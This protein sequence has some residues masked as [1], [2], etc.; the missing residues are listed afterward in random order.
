M[1]QN[2][3]S[4]GFLDIKNIVKDLENSK[5]IDDFEIYE[6]NKIINIKIYKKSKY[7]PGLNSRDCDIYFDNV[8]DKICNM[9]NLCKFKAKKKNRSIKYVRAR[10]Y[11]YI[12]NYL[13]YMK[14]LSLGI[15]RTNVKFNVNEIGNYFGQSHCSVRNTYINKMNCLQDQKEFNKFYEKYKEL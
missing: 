4:K 5:I 2:N 12:I 3:L 11:F 10:H 8:W 13:D 14:E 6:S 7:R 9:L 1:D 15:K